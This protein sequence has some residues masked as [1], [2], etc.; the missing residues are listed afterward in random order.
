MAIAGFSGRG[1]STLALHL[2]S[3]G[4]TFVSNDRVMVE[5]TKA[6]LLMHGVAKQPRINP[7]TALSNPDLVGIVSETE[8]RR[9]E[10]LS[11]GELW[12]LEDKYD[13]PVDQCFGPERFVL[14]APMNALVVLE[15]NR[16]KEPLVIEQV[17]PAKHSDLLSAFRKERGLFYLSDDGYGRTHNPIG[18]YADLLRDCPV[19]RMAGGIDFEKAADACLGLLETGR[20]TT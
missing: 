18:E 1:K 3:K 19:V 11:E 13:A 17:D 8:R 12:A 4:A 15:W 5:K 6:G 7:G 10:S 9:L 2:M 16:D 14:E 20:I